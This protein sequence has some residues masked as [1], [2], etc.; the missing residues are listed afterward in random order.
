MATLSLPDYALNEYATQ[1][2]KP[3]VHVFPPAHPV[4]GLLVGKTYTIVISGSFLEKIDWT[5]YGPPGDLHD[6]ETERITGSST[7][8]MVVFTPTASGRY[9]LTAEITIDP[10]RSSA[11]A[12][13]NFRDT[14]R[15]SLF[16]SS[17]PPETTSA[18]AAALTPGFLLPSQPARFVADRRGG[19]A[20]V[21]HARPP[22]TAAILILHGCAIALFIGVP[23]LIILFVILSRAAKD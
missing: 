15:F 23:F 12:L 5:L 1:R 6:P 19:H 10:T 7:N 8:R 22:S 17:P 9:L 14:L 18:V 20:V 21:V 4:A 3:A 16:A 2:W 13:R 11:A